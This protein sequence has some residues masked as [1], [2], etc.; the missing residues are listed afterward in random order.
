[1][2]IKLFRSFSYWVDFLRDPQALFVFVFFGLAAVMVT[3]VHVDHC[4]HF[5]VTT[6]GS[7][8]V[9]VSRDRIR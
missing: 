3:A 5:N 7:A 2:K 6:T 8:C 9:Y 4:A 1:M